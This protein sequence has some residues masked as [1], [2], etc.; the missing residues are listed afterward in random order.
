[1]VTCSHCIYNIAFMLSD[2]S[3]DMSSLS[4]HSKSINTLCYCVFKTLKLSNKNTKILALVSFN[5]FFFTCQIIWHLRIQYMNAIISIEECCPNYLLETLTNTSEAQSL[6]CSCSRMPEW[7]L[8]VHS[9]SNYKWIHSRQLTTAGSL[10]SYR[11]RKHIAH[12]IILY[13]EGDLRNLSYFLNK[14]K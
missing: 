3:H 6:H 2:I 5:N 10:Q 4:P 12:C 14:I 1:M 9:Q 11:H 7:P 8:L 13:W